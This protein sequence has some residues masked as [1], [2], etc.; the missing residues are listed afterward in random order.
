MAVLERLSDAKLRRAKIYGEIVGYAMNSDASDFVLPNPDRQAQCIRLALGRAGLNPED[1]DIVSTH[2]TGTTSGDTQESKAL[3]QVFNGGGRTA[4]NNTK[5][6]IGH[7]MGAAGVLELAGNLP[8]LDDGVC[9]A[10]INLDRMDP[11]CELPGLV[12]NQP[13]EVG[14]VSVILN[15]SFGMLGINSVVIVKRI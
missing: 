10:T 8:A 3:R 1:V 12:A 2:A 13:R 6:F 4:F 9:H 14:R 11:E 15:N 7:A 5:S